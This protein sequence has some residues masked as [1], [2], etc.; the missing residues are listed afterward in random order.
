MVKRTPVA[1]IVVP[2]KKEKKATPPQLQLPSGAHW[3]PQTDSVVWSLLHGG[4]RICPKLAASLHCSERK[5]HR[6]KAWDPSTGPRQQPRGVAKSITKRRKIVEKLATEVT[7]VNGVSHPKYSGSRGMSGA[8][9]I[10]HQKVSYR[11]VQRDLREKSLSPRV[12]KVVPTA[13]TEK[14]MAF[15]RSLL[16]D[17]QLCSRLV[18][19]DEHTV[20]T[21]DNTGRTQWV[22]K[23]E[24]PIPRI[25]KKLTNSPSW[26]IWAAFGKDWRSELVFFEKNPNPPP[27]KRGRPKKEDPTARGANKGRAPLRKLTRACKRVTSERYIRDCLSPWFVG[28]LRSKNLVFM[29]DGARFHTSN[30]VRKYLE[31]AGVATLEGWPAYSP[32][33]NPIENV[34]AVLDQRIAR[35]HPRTQQE[36]RQAA[37]EAWKSFTVAELNRFQASFVNKLE[38][39]R[40]TG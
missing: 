8:L 39:I 25:Q 26:H 24:K 32:D 5:L 22:G 36:L 17:L 34:W 9:R 31:K 21:R 15:A 33:L 16:G 6:I 7:T 14:R 37:V 11:T 13:C 3:G 12:R 10:Y 4:Y 18:F 40:D 1:P 28:S 20:S 27:K 29:Q 35:K 2:T 23:G 38:G 30:E 19:S